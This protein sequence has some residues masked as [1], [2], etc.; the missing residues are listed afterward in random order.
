MSF[1]EKCLTW[2]LRLNAVLLCS[3]FLMIFLP[4]AWMNAVHQFLGMG[5]LPDRPITQY[6]TRSVSGLYAVHGVLLLAISLK[7]RRY[8]NLIPVIA[9]AHIVFGVVLLI[10][11]VTAP[12]PW[13]WTALEGPPVAAF[14]AVIFWLW[15]RANQSPAAE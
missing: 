15:T 7:P 13:F 11:D 1:A 6:L 4:T 3:A 5:E 8:W 9:W 10:V 14:G 12:M 2:L